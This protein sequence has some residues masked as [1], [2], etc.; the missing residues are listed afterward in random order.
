MLTAEANVALGAQLS[1]L[2][3][4]AKKSM[5]MFHVVAKFLKSLNFFFG[6]LAFK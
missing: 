4:P 3:G 5:E 6:L 1:A 2:P